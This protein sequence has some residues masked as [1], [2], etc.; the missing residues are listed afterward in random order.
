MLGKVTVKLGKKTVVEL[1]NPEGRKAVVMD[2]VE[3]EFDQH[4]AIRITPGEEWTE[5]AVRKGL[6]WS[7]PVDTRELVE[8]TREAQTVKLRRRR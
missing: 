6:T 7:A 1:M 5:I 8:R 4:F 3:V 2:A